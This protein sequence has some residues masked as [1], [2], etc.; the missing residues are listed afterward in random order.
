[1][2]HITKIPLGCDPEFFINVDGKATG[3]EKAIS[4][5]IREVKI[6]GIAVE[7]NPIPTSCRAL[8]RSEIM[9][10][11]NLFRYEIYNKNVKISSQLKTTL[12]K[13][14]FD[15]L[16]DNNKKLGCEPSFSAYSDS[17]IKI[18]KSHEKSTTRFAGGHLHL[19][20]YKKLYDIFLYK[21]DNRFNNDGSI[22]S[23]IHEKI[24]NDVRDFMI[25]L[26]PLLDI[27]V[28]NT[29]VLLDRSPDNIERRKSYGKAGE[30]RLPNHGLEYRVLSNF[31]LRGYP[32]M[33]LVM[34]LT[35]HAFLIHINGMSDPILKAVNQKDI[36]KAINENDFDLAYANFK[37]I[38]DIA[39]SEEYTPYNQ[40]EQDNGFWPINPLNIYKFH[41]LIEQ[42]IDHYFKAD[43]IDAWGSEGVTNKGIHTYI[44]YGFNDFLNKIVRK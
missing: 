41:L 34:G 17:K 4:N 39:F 38:Q 13:E 22:K 3:A 33:S 30:Y 27:M 40:E 9:H 11:I 6:D 20:I 19:G 25:S 12:S 37:K 8:L 2:K 26:V 28:G 43:I 31:W 10:T 16:D 7:L 15:S 36:I 24:C 23:E 21:Y 35:R 42:G 1:M 5:N 29:A 44:N 18:D 14:E 32:L